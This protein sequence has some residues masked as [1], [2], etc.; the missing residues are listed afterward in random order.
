MTNQGVDELSS[1]SATGVVDQQF[2]VGTID[3]T[4]KHR[5]RCEPRASAV[6]PHH[7]QMN[8]HSLPGPRYLESNCGK[9]EAGDFPSVAQFETKLGV[10][11]GA[12]IVGPSLLLTSAFCATSLRKPTAIQ[13]GLGES[14]EQPRATV[15]RGYCLHKHYKLLTNN[16]TPEGTTITDWNEVVKKHD[17]ALLITHEAMRFDTHVASVCL[18]TASA[19]NR[20]RFAGASLGFNRFG[21][22]DH[23]HYVL[24]ELLGDADEKQTKQAQPP[25]PAPAT[26]PQP[27]SAAAAAA[28]PLSAAPNTTTV[29]VNVNPIV[30]YSCPACSSVLCPHH[31]NVYFSGWPLFYYDTDT[32][33]WHLKGIA[34]RTRR[35]AGADPFKSFCSKSSTEDAGPEF[36]YT[37]LHHYGPKLIDSL[38]KCHKL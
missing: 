9:F 29:A 8:Y 11:C 34:S 37:N 13:L 4:I 24:N 36:I 22:K 27:S 16:T 38:T 28:A 14:S 12:V 1:N 7:Y 26:T 35:S 5:R 15:V 19:P 25:A 2:A 17:L 32:N 10:H 33:R 30:S 21:N 3:D 23:I 31:V 6:E 18:N 20:T